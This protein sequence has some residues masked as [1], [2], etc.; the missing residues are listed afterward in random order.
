MAINN[1][2][3]EVMHRVRVKLYTNH[4]PGVEGAYIA[5]TDDEA[6]LDVK[7]VCAAMKNRGGFTGSYDDLVSNVNQFFDEQVYQLCDGFAVH[8][9][10]Y[11]VLPKVGK[12]FDTVTEGVTAEDHPLTFHIRARAKLLK[13]AKLIQIVVEGIANIDGYIDEVTDV[14]TGAVNETLTPGSNVVITGYKIKAAGSNADVGIYIVDVTGSEVLKITGNYAVNDPKK[15]I[16]IV[17]ALTAGNYAVKIVTQYSAGGALLKE[18][19]KILSR[20][21]TVI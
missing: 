6:N 15:V 12:T 5:R 10:Y 19:R 1:N 18:P 4:L 16:F 20:T 14:S 8:N 21:L 7:Q 2:V 17:P 3:D 11:T 13:I 9:D